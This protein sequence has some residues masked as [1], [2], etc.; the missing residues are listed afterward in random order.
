MLKS[1]EGSIGLDIELLKLNSRSAIS[2]SNRRKAYRASYSSIDNVGLE[3]L[4]PNKLI[5][6]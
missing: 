3:T 4:R 6:T 1:V 2:L 5:R